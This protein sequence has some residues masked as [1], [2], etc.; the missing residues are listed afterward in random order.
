MTAAVTLSAWTDM[1][2][3]GES[4]LTRAAAEPFLAPHL[5]LPTADAYL[6]GWDPRDPR[7][8]PLYGDLTGLPPLLMQVGRLGALARRH[9]T[10]R[11][12][13]PGRRGRRHL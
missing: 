8:S 1:A 10:L 11:G 3:T 9:P 4:L 7:A 6:H 13:G 12:Q 2:C 5:M